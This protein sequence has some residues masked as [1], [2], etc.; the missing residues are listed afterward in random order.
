MLYQTLDDALAHKKIDY[1]IPSSFSTQYIDENS[2]EG[3]FVQC[4]VKVGSTETEHD[5]SRGDSATQKSTVYKI[6][7]GDM[8]IRLIDT[9][10][11]GDVRGAQADAQNLSN[12]LR[13][14]NKIPKL[15][16]IIILLKPN[17]SRLTLLFR[18]CV[19]ELLSSLHRDAAR[20]I[21]WGFTNTRQSNYMPGDVYK[22]LEKLLQ[23]HE[24][25]G[26]RLNW[27]TVFCFDSESFRCL[28]AKKQ[29]GIEMPHMEDF[30]RSWECSVKETRRLLEHFINIEPHQV[31]STISLNRAREL[32][33]Q[34]TEPMASITDTIQRT[35]ALNKD[36]VDE[37]SKANCKG[38]KLKQQLH[39]ERIEIQ[40]EKLSYP[41]TVCKHYDCVEMK[42]VGG[43]KRPIY[44]SIC[45]D[46]CKLKDVDEDTVGHHQLMGCAAF[47]TRDGCRSDNCNQCKHH[48][49]EHMHISYSQVE[50]V[51]QDVDPDIQRSIQA[52]V[53]DI[54]LKKSMISSLK[55]RIK[56]AEKELEEIRDA[57]AKFG[58]FLKKN[59]IAPYNDAMLAYLDEMIKEERQYVENAKNN[60]ISASKNEQRL[61]GLEQSKRSYAER[62]KL[63]ETHMNQSAVDTPQLLLD[64]QGV[65]DL[66]NQLCALK[67]WGKNLQDMHSIV[68]WS[69]M[70]DFQEQQYRPR[71]NN[72]IWKSLSYLVSGA[73]KVVTAATTGLIG[74]AVEA[75]HR[76][77]KRPAEAA[78]ADGRMTRSKMRK[79]DSGSESSP[80]FVEK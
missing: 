73:S 12:I 79:L 75:P 9:P 71:I 11:V 42:T 65:D 54:K 30:H 55:T 57:A 56:E 27:N 50:S 28:A 25:L 64:E 76:A 45:H 6:R 66:F 32:I 39:F 23:R 40:V 16:G 44:K 4:D 46:R 36:K 5:G 60:N 51:V 13:T 69:Q 80:D 15:D 3:S 21:V 62:I 31:R 34:L 10:G 33:S 74:P 41:R 53:S 77:S 20:N 70:N 52:N 43:T 78:Q 1:V 18:F 48:W 67:K 68:D 14:L 2:P 7:L 35:I 37:L 17:T 19:K 59:S 72:N 49:Q 22:P 24:S 38:K 63:L 26:L 29:Q 61:A 58:L 47:K 8:F